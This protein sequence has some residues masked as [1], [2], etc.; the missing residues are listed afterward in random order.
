MYRPDG[1]HTNDIMYLEIFQGKL[2]RLM[3]IS[4]MF[5]SG[6]E[7]WT[8]YEVS[9]A[10]YTDLVTDGLGPYSSWVTVRTLEAGKIGYN[11]DSC[12]VYYSSILINFICDVVIC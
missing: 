7:V 10:L 3:F 8:V 4:T 1:R 2:I 12:K 5:Y 6:L 11:V 9:V